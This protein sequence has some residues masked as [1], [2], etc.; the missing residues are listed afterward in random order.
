MEPYQ[1]FEVESILR[2]CSTVRGRR[3]QAERGSA[4]RW[5]EQIFDPDLVG[6]TSDSVKNGARAM[7]SSSATGTLPGLWRAGADWMAVSRIGAS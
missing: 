5:V 7:R 2:E 1:T 6:L 4:T 3:G